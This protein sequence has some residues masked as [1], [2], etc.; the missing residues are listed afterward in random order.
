MSTSMWVGEAGDSA[1]QQQLRSGTCCTAWHL[2]HIVCLHRRPAQAQHRP[3]CP[4]PASHPS[5]HLWDTVI[6]GVGQQHSISRGAGWV[7]CVPALNEG[8]VVQ[9]AVLLQ[10]L[11]RGRMWASR[12]WSLEERPGLMQV[13]DRLP[14][15]VGV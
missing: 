11:H 9:V 5:Q 3:A 14:C 7:P 15:L 1:A 13:C 8:A 12:N 2:V 4:A 6:H 10:R